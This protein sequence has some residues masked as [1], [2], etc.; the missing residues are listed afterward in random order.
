MQICSS[1]E[2]YPVSTVNF[3]QRPIKSLKVKKVYEDGF[4]HLD[5]FLHESPSV[6][7]QGLVKDLRAYIKSKNDT[8][9]ETNIIAQIGEGC[10][11]T[12]F[13]I[14]E[15]KVLKCSLENPLEYR[16]H[17]PDFDIPFLSEVEKFGDHYFVVEAKADTSDVTK[18]DCLDVI[19]RVY[20]GGCEPSRDL[21]VHT[22][23]QVGKLDGKAY[24]LDTRAAMP[25]PDEFSSFIY[26]FCSEHRCVYHDQL[27]N[28]DSW[29]VESFRDIH[30]DET[31]RKNLS[32]IQGCAMAQEVIKDN[33]K[34]KYT[35]R[36]KGFYQSLAVLNIGMQCKI[37][38]LVFKIA[39]KCSRK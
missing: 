9:K 11:S 16:K 15:N 27:L 6:H 8:F 23:R 28:A 21:N 22:L 19:K 25:Q 12:V 17:N 34:Y 33:V 31:P 29:G 36:H 35:S 18:A 24:L 38:D 7:R 4:F 5:K 10:F 14:G 39:E 1:V 2:K 3:S 13:D 26:N 37:K 20:Q 32:F 30:V